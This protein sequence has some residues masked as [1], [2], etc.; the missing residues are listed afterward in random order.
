MK[1]YTFIINDE[2]VVH[3]DM[4]N[5]YGFK[6]AQALVNRDYPNALHIRFIPVVMLNRGS[7]NRSWEKV[8][9]HVPFGSR[10]ALEVDD[11]REY[12]QYE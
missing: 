11:W 12:L 4:Y 6:E 2:L 3:M 7:H 1:T 10:S 5:E 8:K 9:I